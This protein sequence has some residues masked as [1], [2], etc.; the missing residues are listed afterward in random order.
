[1]RVRA[2]LLAMCLS[3]SLVA[4]D[5]FELYRNGA[6]ALEEGRADEAISSFDAAYREE[7]SPALLF[8]LGEAHCMA[9]HALK[10]SELYRGYLKK[11]P[12]GPNSERARARIAA[13]FGGNDCPPP[14]PPPRLP[15]PPPPTEARA[16]AAPVTPP[17]F[18]PSDPRT[19]RPLQRTEEEA[20]PKVRPA[21]TPASAPALAPLPPRLEP[22]PAPPAAPESAF[23]VGYT[24]R[25][26][27]VNGASMGRYATT[28]ALGGAGALYTNGFALG[29]H[30][31]T[32]DNA[33]YLGFGTQYGGG[34]ETL[35]RYELSW[36]FAWRPADWGA[37]ISPRV[38]FRL[39]AMFVQSG[40]LTSSALD[41]GIVIAPQAGIDFQVARFLVLSVGAGYDE[42][43]GP[44][45]GPGASVSGYSI[46]LGASFRL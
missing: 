5:A 15:A 40:L 41:P 24:A 22:I 10:A 18:S 1:M 13:I 21:A 42:N 43:L 4:G 29:R 27:A 12:R 9:G 6:M 39:G 36:Q 2:G 30:T 31:A 8:W 28:N 38:G 23:F 11:R 26:L 3:G 25:L 19:I 46:D 33:V 34:S 17:E 14:A 7:H 45:L 44:D 37:W 32:F 35:L 20:L 16:P